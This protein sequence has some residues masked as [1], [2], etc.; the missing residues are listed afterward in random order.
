MNKHPSI[1]ISG[2]LIGMG[3]VKEFGKVD[4]KIVSN[5]SFL[6]L[7]D[8]RRERAAPHNL[9]SSIAEDVGWP[10]DVILGH[11]VW[12]MFLGYCPSGF[13]SSEMLLVSLF[14]G[15]GNPSKV[16]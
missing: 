1:P 12:N 4:E 3:R 8:G 16:H 11:S 7:E 10:I 9:T 13:G 15:F 2:P 14:Q 6:Y 5:F